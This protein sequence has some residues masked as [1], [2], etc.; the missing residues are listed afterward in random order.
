MKINNI[1]MEKISRTINSWKQDS[2]VLIKKVSVVGE[3]N[4]HDSPQFTTKL[5][6]ENGE[7]VLNIDSPTFMGGEGKSPSPLQICLAGIASCYAGT[8]ASIAA[9]KGVRLE[10]L[11]VTAEAIYDLSKTFG[12]TD[13]PILKEITFIVKLKSSSD[14]KVI[15]EIVE[16]AKERCPAMYSLMTPIQPNIKIVKE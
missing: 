5:K 10:N 7:L 2:N 3:W 8:I 1:D 6:Y 12:L 15:N 9:E 13:N 11:S 4:L 16:N 14:T